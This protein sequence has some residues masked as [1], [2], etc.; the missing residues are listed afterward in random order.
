VEDNG[1]SDIEEEEAETPAETVSTSGQPPSAP[2]DPEVSR[3]EQGLLAL[4]RALMRKV[5]EVRAAA[6]AAKEE[7]EATAEAAARSAALAKE[8][9]LRTMEGEMRAAGDAEARVTQLEN[10]HT[11]LAGK[12]GSAAQEINRLRNTTETEQT[13][14][15]GLRKE[16]AAADH[17]AD[18]LTKK[19]KALVK[20]IKADIKARLVAELQAE[21]S[22]AK[23]NS[24]KVVQVGELAKRLE[25]LKYEAT[26]LQ[27]CM[28]A[29]RLALRDENKRHHAAL[30]DIRSRPQGGVGL[31]GKQ[32]GGAAARSSSDAAAHSSGVWIN[33]R[34][35]AQHASLADAKQV[36]DSALTEL[37]AA[38]DNERQTTK[39]LEEAEAALCT[40]EASRSEQNKQL[41]SQLKLARGSTE[42]ACVAM[43]DSMRRQRERFA[44][45]LF[46]CKSDGVSYSE[47][48]QR[49]KVEC[50]KLAPQLSGGGGADGGKKHNGQ[51]RAG[52]R[53]AEGGGN[54]ELCVICQGGKKST[55]STARH[56]KVDDGKKHLKS[57]G[58]AVSA[59]E[60]AESNAG[61]NNH[62]GG[63]GDDIMSILS[64][65]ID[66]WKLEADAAR[67]TSELH[68]LI[69]TEQ[70]VKSEASAV[71]S[72]VEVLSLAL[73]KAQGGM[74]DAQ[75]SL[76]LLQG[77][78]KSI[79]E[80][81]DQAER[82]RSLQAQVRREKDESLRWRVAADAAENDL[83][84]RRGVMEKNETQ[85][86]LMDAELQNVAVEK[87][88]KEAALNSVNAQLARLQRGGAALR[89]SQ[90]VDVSSSNAGGQLAAIQDEVDRTKLEIET[91]NKGLK[92]ARRTAA[93]IKAQVSDD[94]VLD[95]GDVLAEIAEH[96][97]QAEQFTAQ[98]GDFWRRKSAQDDARREAEAG[99]ADASSRLVETHLV[100][101]VL[102]ENLVVMRE[103]HA[104]LLRA[105]ELKANQR[106]AIADAGSFAC[107]GT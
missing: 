67:E 34:L 27:R 88:S 42:D 65:R 60:G 100:L 5:S 43:E 73:L 79:S 99:V 31:V 23:G 98:A 8:R 45:A 3:E 52:G 15:Q 25:E 19:S 53:A 16:K 30:D 104:G 76:E 17:E 101:Q 63:G 26:D 24:N 89:E 107:S 54:Q 55:K 82:A 39:T 75:A 48:A 77:H 28:E 12:V 22:A 46:R 6:K 93:A 103:Q 56:P 38:K 50:T 85:L 97:S 83:E 35:K 72:K 61:D 96:E 81:E 11:E 59:A 47:L 90:K 21:V 13:R 4:Q 37:K 105:R 74:N 71:A 51:L 92:R 1:E 57:S 69:E 14:T 40:A 95:N 86:R 64:L 18:E 102:S 70:A 36:R 62:R 7:A 2:Y 10:E 44:S 9:R 32:G 94:T 58:Q 87:S 78:N 20:Q 80:V 29:E 41:E 66:L 49:I 68:E 33:P 106:L 91:V 84:T